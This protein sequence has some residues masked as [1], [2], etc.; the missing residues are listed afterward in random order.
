LFGLRFLFAL[1]PSVFFLLAG[2][3]IW[4]YPITEQRHAEMRA[5]LARRAETPNQERAA[6]AS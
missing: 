1:L 5:E 6:T 3:I 2:A 4:K